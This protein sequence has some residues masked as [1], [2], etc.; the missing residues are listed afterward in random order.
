M[1]SFLNLNFLIIAAELRVEDVINIFFIEVFFSRFLTRGIIL[2]ISPTLD[3]WNQIRFP[4]SLFFEKKQN[5]SLNLI[6]SSF[7][8]KILI[9][10][11]IGENIIINKTIDW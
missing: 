9:N 4:L 6:L 5:F 1:N 11:I 3:P 7:F 10:K 8:F 2:K